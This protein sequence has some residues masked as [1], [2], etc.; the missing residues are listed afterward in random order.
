MQFITNLV[1]W[2]RG[3]RARR[4][5]IAELESFD[6]HQLRDIGIIDRAMIPAFV[7]GRSAPAPDGA[8]PLHLP[9]PATRSSRPVLRVIQGHSAA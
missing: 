6:D 9:E 1:E 8:I 3:H 5:A 4:A 2:L 7:E